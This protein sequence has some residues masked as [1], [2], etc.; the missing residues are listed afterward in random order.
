MATRKLT[1]QIS[2]EICVKLACITHRTMF[3]HPICSLIRYVFTPR[4][5]SLQ[6]NSYTQYFCMV[7]LWN[8]SDWMVLFILQIYSI[9]SEA[10]MKFIWP[11]FGSFFTSFV[12]PMKPLIGVSITAICLV[13]GMGFLLYL[14]FC[15]DTQSVCVRN[16][17]KN[18]KDEAITETEQD[19]NT[20]GSTTGE[21]QDVGKTRRWTKQW[22]KIL[23]PH[24]QY[25]SIPRLSIQAKQ[26]QKVL[27]PNGLSM[28]IRRSLSQ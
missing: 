9:R 8:S 18:N 5:M 14:V 4:W 20:I 6:Q 16:K 26:I 2:F 23:S 19:S 1:N 28:R 13:A 27:Q 21:L 15:K 17:A 22:G 10:L 7:D 24:S 25:S 11:D 3:A 12:G